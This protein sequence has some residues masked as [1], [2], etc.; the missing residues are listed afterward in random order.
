MMDVSGSGLLLLFRAFD[1][2]LLYIAQ[3]LGM[4]IKEV[5]VNWQEIDGEAVIITVILTILA[6]D[7][8][9]QVRSWCHFGAGCKWEGTYSSLDFVMCLVYGHCAAQVR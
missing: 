5:P 4:P 1:V 9:W 3:R 2:E 7:V 6:V 8:L